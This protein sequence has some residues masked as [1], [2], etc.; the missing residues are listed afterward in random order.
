MK[1]G[2]LVVVLA[3]LTV[4]VWASVY[5]KYAD[6]L[7]FYG[8]T[9][10]ATTVTTAANI[11]ITGRAPAIFNVTTV[12]TQ[13]ITEAGVT[14][15]TFYFRA[16]DADGAS[17]FVDAGST[18]M[19]NASGEV[20]R[21]NTTCAAVQNINTTVREYQCRVVGLYWFDGAVTW[22]VNASVRDAE[23]TVAVNDS[24]T[25]TLSSTMAFAMGPTSLTWASF[26][27]DATNQTS[28]NDP[29]LLNNTGNANVTRGNVSITVINLIGETNAS[30]Y[31]NA[32]NFTVDTETGSNNECVVTSV[33]GA[34][35]LNNTL[36]NVTN[37]SLP[38]G[39]FTINSGD[40]TTAQEQLYFCL[41][42]VSTATTTSAQSYSTLAGG[43]WTV[44]VG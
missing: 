35:G 39:N 8:I 3:A 11:T 34:R 23:G 24:G 29:I 38:R 41:D 28:S 18:G 9:G 17:D 43:A 14:N 27:S 16:S 12:A 25:F 1:R 31:L 30:Q 4:L 36:I 22:T 10:Q 7:N 5:I 44:R 33:S 15:V 2:S 37:T 21:R 26:G 19:F 20:T 13:S 40:N 32:S 42:D 6:P